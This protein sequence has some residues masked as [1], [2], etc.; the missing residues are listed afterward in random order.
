M[1][2]SSNPTW[3]RSQIKYS[4]SGGSIGFGTGV[5]LFALAW[6]RRINR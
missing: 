6:R 5:L 2:S 1:H 4:R 3:Y